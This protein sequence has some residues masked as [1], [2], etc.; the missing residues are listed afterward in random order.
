[1]KSSVLLPLTL[2]LVS[3]SLLA[4]DK[5]D[6]SKEAKEAAKRR[7]GLERELARAKDRAA[8]AEKDVDDQAKDDAATAERAAFEVAFASEK[9]KYFEEVD[10]PRKLAEAKLELDHA[11]DGLADAREELEQLELMYKESEIGDKT[12]DMVLARGRRGLERAQRRL[13]IEKTKIAALEGREIPL[14]GRRLAADVTE[15]TRAAEKVA[16]DAERARFEKTLAARAAKDEVLRLTEE[17][18]ALGEAK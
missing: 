16:R 18:A 6:P 4:Q 3:P 10:A 2:A 14:E 1:M 11:T 9:L 12:K 8:R 17:L 5:P 15:K 7:P 13:A